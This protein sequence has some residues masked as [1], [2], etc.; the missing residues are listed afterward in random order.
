MR[1]RI[2]Q[3]LAASADPRVRATAQD[4]EFSPISTIHS[5]C[6][7]L[8]REHA[9]SAGVD[10]AFKAADETQSRLIAE[11][12]WDAV[13]RRILASGDE[14]RSVL[15]RLGREDAGRTLTEIAERLRG[16]GYDPRQVSVAAAAPSADGA[17]VALDTALAEFDTAF[18]EAK[19]GAGKK[20]V[21]ADAL[22]ALSLFR[23]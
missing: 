20:K 7:R 19:R 21:E 4:V 12:A 9:V 15:R 3:R 17:L 14:R 2:A 1:T 13:E 18:D 6:A 16:L 11:E 8:L 10:P 22:E 23:H 5:F